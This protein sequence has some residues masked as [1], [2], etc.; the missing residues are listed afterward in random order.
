[1]EEGK[2]NGIYDNTFTRISFFFLFKNPL[3][4]KIYLFHHT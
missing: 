1:M 2:Q 4:A 3:R